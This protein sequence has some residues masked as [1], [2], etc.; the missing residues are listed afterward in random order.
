MLSSGAGILVPHGD[1]AAMAEAIRVVL[2][3]DVARERMAAEA[4]RLAPELQ[5]SA[6]AACYLGLGTS[7]M[8]SARSVAI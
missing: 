7:L 4:R 1:P 2:T 6:V 8:R 5:W 3:D